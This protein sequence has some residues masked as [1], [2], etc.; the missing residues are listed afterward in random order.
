MEKLNIPADNSGHRKRLREKFLYGGGR[1]LH[2]YEKLELLLTYCI[3]RRDV[4]PLAKKLLN[5][6]GS[7]QNL[8][9][10]SVKELTDF[11]GITERTAC[12]I[13]ML[14]DLCCTYLEEE[15]LAKPLIKNVTAA[16][17]FAKMKIGG[18]KKESFMLIFLDSR[19]CILGYECVQNG[20]VDHT[21]MYPRE[22][23]SM[24]INYNA[25]GVILIHN[26]PS[27]LCMPSKEDFDMTIQIKKTL[28]PIQITLHDHIIVSAS[29]FY[30]ML[31][32]GKL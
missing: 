1:A 30:S 4:K 26:H 6:F 13:L 11:N 27:G 15:M 25:V 2:K 21:F 22:L 5:H 32:A 8:M 31:N 3:P 14:K 12:M 10:A 17:N 19:N 28:T 18:S 9:N 16:I 23:V 20:T 7:V 29:D 24:C